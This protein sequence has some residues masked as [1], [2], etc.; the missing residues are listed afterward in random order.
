M[1]STAYGRFTGWMVTRQLCTALAAI[2]Q[3]VGDAPSFSQK[4]TRIDYY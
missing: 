2:C 1:H 4:D 3:Y